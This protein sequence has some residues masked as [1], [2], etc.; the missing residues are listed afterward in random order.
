MELLNSVSPYIVA[1]LI[2]YAIAA[3]VWGARL[4]QRVKELEQAAAK[5]DGKIVGLDQNGS[6]GVAVVH[7]KLGQL[8]DQVDRMNE[9]I[10]RLLERQYGEKPA[11]PS[12]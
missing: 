4:D 3:L 6:R 2:G 7:A 1:V 11:S 5:L 10:D 9:K 12:I 8:Q